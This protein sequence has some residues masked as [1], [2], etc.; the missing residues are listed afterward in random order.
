MTNTGRH[1]RGGAGRAIH[2]PPE[3]GS[4]GGVI[5]EGAGRGLSPGL[6]RGILA[7]RR[8]PRGPPKVHTLEI[9]CRLCFG[10]VLYDVRCLRVIKSRKVPNVQASINVRSMFIP[11]L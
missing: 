2:G 3:S 5:V 7:P 11:A 8:G 9:S 6:R 4:N 10:G 1:D